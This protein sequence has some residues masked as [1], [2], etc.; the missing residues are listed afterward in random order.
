MMAIL[1]R[2]TLEAAQLVAGAALLVLIG[3]SSA[4]RGPSAAWALEPAYEPQQIAR[5]EYRHH[6]VR[7]SEDRLQDEAPEDVNSASSSGALAAALAAC[8]LEWNGKL[9][10]AR[11]Q[12]RDQIGQ[13]LSRA[14]AIRLQP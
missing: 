7:R 2:K 12:G 4:G 1:N 10:V 13:L 6:G 14:R 3:P 11:R 9:N 5:R 8:R